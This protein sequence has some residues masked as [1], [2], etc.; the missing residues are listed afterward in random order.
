[1]TSIIIRVGLI[2]L[3]YGVLVSLGNVI[4]TYFLVELL[5]QFF[6]FLRSIVEPL[7][8]LWDFD[9]SFILIGWSIGLFTLYFIVKVLLVIKSV[10]TSDK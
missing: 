2:A 8:F 5:T 6:C 7:D 10:L 9:T 3:I 1:M 4:N